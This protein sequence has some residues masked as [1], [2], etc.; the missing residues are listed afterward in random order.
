M[1][2]AAD[3]GNANVFG[4]SITEEERVE[5]LAQAE[6]LESE[7]GLLADAGPPP[8]SKDWRTDGW[9]TDP[10]YQGDCQACVAF[11]TCAAMESRLRIYA[12]DSALDLDLSEAHLFAC[13]HVGGCAVGW[14]FEPALERARS[15]GVGLETDFPYEPTDQ[16]C[17]D[18]PPAARVNG[19]SA[20]TTADARKQTIAANGPAIG[21]MRAF[22]DLLYYDAGVYRH[23]AGGQTGLHAVCV[24]GYDDPGGFWIVKNSWGTDW[25]E[26]GFFRIAYGECGLDD[27][28]PFFDPGVERVTPG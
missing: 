22:Q 16:A 11:A 8:E 7:G 2:E 13:G 18:I 17:P 6:Q 12:D 21:G 27:E 26:E 28:F 14:N 15:E 9:V 1:A 3:V 10:R 23:V 19:W 20:A 25:G 24:V 4:L 5:L